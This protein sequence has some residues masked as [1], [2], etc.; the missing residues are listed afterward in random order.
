M[1]GPVVMPTD[2]HV[3]PSPGDVWLSG[4]TEGQGSPTP[5]AP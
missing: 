1:A 4:R 2:N 3:V 5:P